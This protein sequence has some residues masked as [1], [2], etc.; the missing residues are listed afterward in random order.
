MFKECSFY[1]LFNIYSFI[2]LIFIIKQCSLKVPWIFSEY[3][4]C[5]PD[6]HTQIKHSPNIRVILLL[7]IITNDVQRTFAEFFFR[8]FYD[9]IFGWNFIYCSLNVRPLL[10]I[11]FILQILLII[12]EHSLFFFWNIR[13]TY[14]RLKFKLMYNEC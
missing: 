14:V 5:S 11:T 12:S 7:S 6:I 3:S 1:I 13:W 8:F 9:L 2:Y 10:Y 4:Q